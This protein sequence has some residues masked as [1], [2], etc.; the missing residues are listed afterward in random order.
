MPVVSLFYDKCVGNEDHSFNNSI[1]CNISID[2]LYSDQEYLFV[3]G[4]EAIDKFND[5]I[6]TSDCGV[7]GF[8]IPDLNKELYNVKFY[9]KLVSSIPIYITVVDIYINIL[10]DFAKANTI[11]NEEFLKELCR[12][13]I[14][15]NKCLK[16]ELL[17][18]N[19]ILFDSEITI[20]SNISNTVKQIMEFDNYD[21]NMIDTPVDEDGDFP[22]L[23]TKLFKYQKSS[24][25]WMIE[26]EKNIK[27]GN[28]MYFNIND[29]VVLGDVYYDYINETFSMA[30]DRNNVKFCGG[31]LIDEVGLGKT[32]QITT[33]SLL[34]PPDEYSQTRENSNKFHS[35]ATLILCPNTLCGQW[36]RELQQMVTKERDLVIISLLTKR[37]LKKYTYEDL[38][39]ADFVIVPFTFLDN[40]AFVT[41]WI[42]KMSS[43]LNY[44]KSIQFNHTRAKEVFDEL[45][46]E[47]MEDPIENIEQTYPLIQL[48]HWYRFVIDEFHEIHDNK[49][50][51]YVSNIIPHIDS[52]YRWMV[53]ATPFIN[54]NSLY[55]TLNFLTK[56]EN[57]HGIKILTNYDIIEY[58]GT[59]CFRRNTKDNIKD[60]YTIPPVKEEVK[61]LKFTSTERMMYN[62][63]IANPNN[64]KFGVYLRQLCCH[65]KLADE[66]KHALSTCKT[67][68]DIEKMMVEHYRKTALKSKKIYVITFLRINKIKTKIN[69]YFCRHKRYKVNNILR[70]LGCKFKDDEKDKD[71]DKDD[72]IHE[73][74][75]DEC[76]QT[77]DIFVSLDEKDDG[78]FD[79]V[80][81]DNEDD[82][83]RTIKNVFEVLD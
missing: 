56:Y 13:H 77:S 40:K 79:E 44:N 63:Y 24:V 41:K 9:W 6:S 39:I 37:E 76:N 64:N 33:L 78:D 14:R 32:L 43:R 51:N 10:S 22:L 55:N 60:E 82:Y 19:R 16:Q 53:T 71:D 46:K 29:E 1:T 8:K 5:L 74:V 54:N 3:E 70:E 31:G 26:F 30:S 25:Y 36:K 48:I 11:P 67:L 61:W 65:P 50:Y 69:E 34:N 68:K 2:E 80:V 4:D 57:S 58:L 12:Y 45:G 38:L 72:L 23:T 52:T 42:S 20:T 18:L 59:K 73:S 21:N 27:K 7:F 15:Y 49:A 75:M 66:T 28:R 81:L 83:K 47:L 62:A 17:Y 35:S